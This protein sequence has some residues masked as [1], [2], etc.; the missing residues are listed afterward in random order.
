MKK[1]LRF[2]VAAG[3]LAASMA[4]AWAADPFA[5][6]TFDRSTMQGWQRSTGSSAMA[7]GRIAFHPP[8]SDK[9]PMRFG[10]AMT[11]PYRVNGAGVLLRTD[12]PKLIDIGF[13]TRGAAETWSASF[14]I[15][16]TPAWSYDPA[17]APGERHHNFL[18]SGT[19]WLIVGVATIAVGVAAMSVIDNGT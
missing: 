12:A 8:K 14:N 2:V 13:N 15:G 7:Y 5:R 19:S 11:A 6:G 3:V 10:L 1:V 9:S 4:P 17:R 16:S 18:D